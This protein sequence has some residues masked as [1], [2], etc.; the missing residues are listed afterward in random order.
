MRIALLAVALGSTTAL[1][2]SLM[3]YPAPRDG[4]SGATDAPCG[5]APRVAPVRY[6]PGQKLT[7]R[8]NVLQPH[9]NPPGSGRLRVSFSPA[10]DQ[11]FEQNVL[12][13]TGERGGPGSAEVT[14]PSTPCAGCTLR[15]GQHFI[16]GAGYFSCADIVLEGDPVDAG[17]PPVVVTD[18]GAVVAPE[19]EPT[20]VDAGPSA[21]PFSR[22]AA[23]EPEPPHAEHLEGTLGCSASAGLF[24]PALLLL[25]AAI[26]KPRADMKRSR[27]LT[28]RNV[29]SIL[30]VVL[31]F[32]ACDG[33]MGDVE[34]APIG[35][36][37]GGSATAGSGGTAGGSVSGTAGG[38]TVSGTAGG[39]AATAGG[40]TQPMPG[41]PDFPR[42]GFCNEATS[43]PWAYC[44]DFDGLG[45]GMRI[46]YPAPSN[47]KLSFNAHSHMTVTG[48]TCET[49]MD[50]SP[51][52]LNG[53]A[54]INSEDSGFG[55]S[56]TRLKQPFDFAGRTG[57]LRFTGVLKGH[58]RMQLAV[59]LSPQPTNNMPDLRDP[60]IGAMDQSPAVTVLFQGEGGW[61]FTLLT[62]KDGN[63]TYTDHGNGPLNIDFTGLHE[64]DIYVTRTSLELKLD[65]IRRVYSTFAD[66]GFDKAYV[67][68]T[69][70][71][72]NPA[73]DGFD[74]DE[75]NRFQ[76][77]NIAFDGP[78]YAVNAL[79]PMG[80]Q[81][82]LFRAYST[83]GC[84]VR[85]VQ[86][87]GPRNLLWGAWHTWHVRLN[88]T[89]PVN[90][91]DITCATVP[92]S[93]H[94]AGAHV[95]NIE[96]IRP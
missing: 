25:L 29:S 63:N 45:V 23:T 71:S 69:Q 57:H 80:S 47:T 74:G 20:P 19:P 84:T 38:G 49:S 14:L 76:W 91:S 37:A 75:K 95:Q 12:F 66:I 90:V 73:K 77:D 43:T 32:T 15:F 30:A 33:V 68:L 64:F 89:N 81:D 50:C 2:H 53:S 7:V 94:Y 78:S 6:R 70:V 72:Y 85:G 56:V 52:L 39:S 11:G 92:D 61:P 36:R 44:E 5:Q 41:T 54:F 51:Y 8:W 46:P 35:G 40:T 88:D 96:T 27:R 59:Q 10:N 79:T 13:E 18:A 21:P 65:G 9:E 1:A 34:P 55:M 48:V 62:W 24:T 60:S 28:M 31:S 82:V 3:V 83:S 67:H 22:V 93:P 86:A 42:D 4:D 16:N 58:P 26:K 87:D 17:A